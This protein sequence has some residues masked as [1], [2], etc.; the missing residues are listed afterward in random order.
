M[1]HVDQLI[2]AHALR[3]L[4]PDDERI[5]TAHLSYC[6]RCRTQLREFEGVA[7]ALAYA[8]PSMAAPTELRGRVLAAIAPVAAP[9]TAPAAAVPARRRAP[10][11]GWWP[12]PSL[13]AVPALGAA[14]VALALWNVSLHDSLSNRSVTGV[15]PVGGVANAVSYRNGGVTLFAKLPTAA[16]GHV[17]EAWVIHGANSTPLAAGTFRGGILSFTLTRDASRGDTI[18]I[19]LEPGSGGPAPRGPTVASGQLT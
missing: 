9:Q 12:R 19:T 1:E 14:V 7:A 2:P 16:A 18:S 5:V 6:E 15:T 10:R 3:A 11:F 4:D 17:Y 8:S 13:V